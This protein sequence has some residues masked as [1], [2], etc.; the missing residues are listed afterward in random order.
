[1]ELKP[2]IVRRSLE[3]YCDR[4]RP[5][6]DI[7]TM[8]HVLEHLQEPSAAVRQLKDL[9]EPGGSSASSK[10]FGLVFWLE[11]LG[12]R[13][14]IYE[15]FYLRNP[16]MHFFYPTRR[17]LS[18]T[19]EKAGFEVVRTEELDAFD[20][21]RIWKRA[22]GLPHFVLHLAGPLVNLSRFTCRDNIVIVARKPVVL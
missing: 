6:F 12:L 13:S 22:S 3:E 10:G 17:S 16:N 1:M 20:W 11:K 21:T 4:P 15:L 7:L 2:R 19:L 9:L 18:V 5:V 8:W 14:L